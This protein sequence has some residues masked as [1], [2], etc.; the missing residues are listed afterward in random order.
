MSIQYTT[1]KAVKAFIYMC[2]RWQFVWSPYV[3]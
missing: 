1:G 3:L 2:R